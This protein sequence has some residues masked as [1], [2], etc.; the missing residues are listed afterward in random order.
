MKANK[1][2]KIVTIVVLITI[3]TMASILGVFK[4]KGYK[5]VDIIQKY[6]LGMEFTSSRVID[7][8]V[9]TT[10]ETTIYDSEGNEVFDISQEIEYTEENGYKK[11]ENEANPKEILTIENYKNAKSILKNRL[12]NLGVDQYKI[13]LDET[14]GNL[15]IRI[16]ENDETDNV[17]FNLLLPGTIEI[18]DT[19]TE[20]VLIGA[21]RFKKADILYSYPQSEAE[22]QTTVFLQIKFDQEGTKKLEEISKIYVKK[23]TEKTNENGETEQIDESKTVGIYYC[24]MPMGE[25]TLEGIVSNKVLYIGIGAGT[26]PQ[27]LQEYEKN[28]KQMVAVLNSGILPI[29]YLETSYTEMANITKQ[30]KDIAMYIAISI[31]VLMIVVFVIKLKVKGILA[32][33]LQIGYIAILL[34]L[35]RYANVKITIEGILGILIA[36]ILNYIY[37]YK[38][39]KNAEDDLVKDVTKKYALKLIPIYIIAIICSFNKIANIYSLGMTIVWGIILMYLYNLTITKITID[40]IKE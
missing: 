2:I 7:L 12:K 31:I 22:T 3:I 5:V 29:N 10:V 26:D 17:L 14:N 32:S 19:E 4:L 8:A 9:D 20:E 21:E 40:T 33:V 34:L 16:P 6:K 27:T 35:I 24:G 15:K 23:I 39:F 30:Q 13:A 28:A 25:V 11:V 1:I 36:S 38:I 18:K 37:L